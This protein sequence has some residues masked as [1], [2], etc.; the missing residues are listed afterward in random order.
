MRL[1]ILLALS[2]RAILLD[3]ALLLARFLV[4]LCARWLGG[5]F[6]ATHVIFI[7]RLADEFDVLHDVLPLLL[8]ELVRELGHVHIILV[9]LGTTRGI[10]G[11]LHLH[12]WLTK[13][14]I[15]LREFD[16]AAAVGARE[17]IVLV[18]VLP[19]TADGRAYLSAEAALLMVEL[20]VLLIEVDDLA[21]FDLEHLVG[22]DRAACVNV[23]VEAEGD[24]A[25]GNLALAGV[26]AQEAGQAALRIVYFGVL[27][28][29]DD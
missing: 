3:R 6:L 22:P 17:M 24:Q 7:E 28:A 26:L 20:L 16:A 15:L 5:A 14:T 10:F 21:V 11:T 9:S 1:P 27:C 23:H 18:A 19:R 25:T 4:Q 13:H 29:A 12:A 2:L 8:H